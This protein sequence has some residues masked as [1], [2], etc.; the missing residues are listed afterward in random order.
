M[1]IDVDTILKLPK[2]KKILILAGIIGIFA[3]LYFYLLYFP[4]YTKYAG[5]QAKVQKL[6]SDLEEEKKVATTLPKFKKEAQELEQLF[7]AALKELPDKKEI[8]SLLM[9]I[10]QMAQESGLQI[11][12]FQPQKENVMDFYEEI[13]VKIKLSGGYHELALFF[14]KVANLSRIV[15]IKDLAI[16]EA[17]VDGDK[18]N[19]NSSCTATTFRF[20]EKSQEA[21]KAKKAK[22]V[23]KP[24]A[25]EKVT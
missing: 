23:K 21:P 12:L 24:V 14:D 19:L 22:K 7:N 11:T 18:V 15:N 1:A 13:P 8:P 2:Q 17:N 20:M 3:F 6:T 16:S 5:L 4:Q 9:N 10:S 25:E